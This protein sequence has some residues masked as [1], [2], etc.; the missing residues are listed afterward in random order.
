[1]FSTVVGI[2]SGAVA[3]AY[4]LSSEMRGASILYEECCTTNFRPRFNFK[5]LINTTFLERVLAGDTG[6]GLDFEQ[7]FTQPTPLYIGVSDFNTAKPHLLHPINR[8]DLLTAI[9]ASI[10]MPG[11]VSLPAVIDGVR[12]IDGA[13]TSPHILEYACESLEATHVLIITNQDKD[14]KHISWIEHMIH[15]TLFRNRTNSTLRAV[16]NWRREIRHEFITRRLATPDT[17]TL[18]VW[19]D[20][21]VTSREKNRERIKATIEKSRVWW[22]ELLS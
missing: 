18:F 20:G 14:T 17:P 22:S 8:L 12:Y 7:I 1:M 5:N 3:G 19:G 10:S 11:A 6:K 15:N 13:S 4:L 21:S 16:A 9:R 2:S